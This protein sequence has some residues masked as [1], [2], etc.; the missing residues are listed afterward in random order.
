MKIFTYKRVSSHSLRKSE[1]IPKYSHTI[2]FWARS[3][4]IGET[5]DPRH[6][7]NGR[8]K[9]PVTWLLQIFIF[10]NNRICW[11][12][13]RYSQQYWWIF[14]RYPVSPFLIFQFWFLQFKSTI[15]HWY[16]PPCVLDM[17]CQIE[18]AKK[19]VWNCWC[20]NSR[21]NNTF[22]KIQPYHSNIMIYQYFNA[23][24]DQ[25]SCQY[26]HI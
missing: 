26:I 9:Q 18:A 11:K 1:N 12:F 13:Q 16:Y 10:P 3:F 15:Q 23:Q 24:F 17:I 7:W 14:Q 22:H 20:S 5:S 8:H 21:L 4:F 25:W 6:H 19:L 2:F